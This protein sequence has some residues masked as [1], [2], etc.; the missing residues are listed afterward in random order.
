MELLIELLKEESLLEIPAGWLS[1]GI[2]VP[3]LGDNAVFD[4]AGVADEGVHAVGNHRRGGVTVV[5]SRGHVLLSL[6]AGNVKATNYTDDNDKYT[7][8]MLSANHLRNRCN[9]WLS[10]HLVFR[11]I[12]SFTRSS[13]SRTNAR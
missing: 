12:C 8:Y 4:D 2:H 10:I 5:D 11:I 3:A 1:D 7:I 13:S 6:L 9:L